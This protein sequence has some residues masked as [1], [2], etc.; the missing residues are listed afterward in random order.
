M[1]QDTPDQVR[2]VVLGQGNPV[3]AVQSDARLRQETFTAKNKTNFSP[4]AG[5][6]IDRSFSL[7]IF[8]CAEANVLF[9]CTPF[10][11]GQSLRP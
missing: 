1:F 5:D 9:S 10:T 4:K 2:L 7:V 6:G 3:A 11:A 8:S